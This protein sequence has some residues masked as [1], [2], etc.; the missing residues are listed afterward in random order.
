MALAERGLTV[1]WADGSA[2]AALYVAK[3]FRT[4]LTCGNVSFGH[5]GSP[6]EIV[7][8]AELKRRQAVARINSWLHYS[9]AIPRTTTS[10]EI[11]HELGTTRL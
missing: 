8:L 5:Q 2:D 3:R 6:A 7:D 11:H 10:R 1:P 4:A 9:V